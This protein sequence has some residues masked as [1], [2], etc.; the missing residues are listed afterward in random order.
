[1]LTSKSVE[2]LLL[3]VV[4]IFWFCFLNTLAGTTAC[5]T[6]TPPTIKV[7]C[8]LVAHTAGFGNTLFLRFVEL[9]TFHVDL[10][11]SF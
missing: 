8:W 4:G 11:M 3:R 10:S 6:V 1:M 2:E 9:L 7:Q 5:A